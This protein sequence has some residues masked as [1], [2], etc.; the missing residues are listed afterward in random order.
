M[1]EI[2]GLSKRFNDNIVLDDLNLHIEKSQVVAI[3]GPSGTGKSTLL[4]CM[5]LLEQPEK[6]S[7]R[8]GDFSMDLTDKTS[9]NRVELRK[10]TAMVFQQFNLFHHKTALQN[11]MEGLITVK[12]LKHADAEELARKHLADV[13]LSDRL[14]HYPQ[15]LSGGQQQRVAIARALAMS[16]EVLLFDEPTSAL[17]PELVGEV[18]DTIRE[19]ARSG[20]TMM[21]VS[22]EMNFVRT[23][24]S[25]V[26][27]LENGKIIED[28]TPVDV[29]NRPKHPRT[30]E[31]LAKM[32]QLN[33]PDYI[34]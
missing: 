14:G 29:F 11:V 13:G 34:I 3:I 16:P 8:I 32:N 17:D 28:G 7:I 19:T 24:A 5:N 4:R 25:R 22:H 15:H 9:H 18:L 10:R 21:L 20:Y 12:K 1:I 2:Q 30:K 26:I 33:G 6:G 27:F 23:V 31:F